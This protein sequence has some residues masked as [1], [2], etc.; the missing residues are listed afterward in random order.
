[1]KLGF[2]YHIVVYKDSE[3]RIFLP[4]YLGLFVDELAK[5]AENIY[6]FA[7][8]SK[9]VTTEQN[10]ELK[11]SNVVLVD[12]GKKQSFPITVILGYFFLRKHSDIANICDKIL[13]R[14]PSPVAPY[15][16]FA[17]KRYTKIHYLMVGDYKEGI[18]HQNFN[19]FKQLLINFFTNINELFQNK[20]I[21]GSGC[22]VN[23]AP[24][25]IKYENLNRNIEI[26]KTTTLTKDNFFNRIDTCKENSNIKL[27]FVGR[28]EKAKGMDELVATFKLLRQNK[29]PV[30]LHLAGW[31]TTDANSY[32]QQLNKSNFTSDAW[33][34][35][36]LLCGNELF[37]L[38]R[39]S[40]IFVLPSYHEGFPRV[41]WEAMANSLPVVTTKV[42]SI[43]KNLQHG[44]NAMLV[45]IK[46]ETELYIAVSDIISD[47]FLRQKLI[48]NAGVLVQ[49]CLMDV[50]VKKIIDYINE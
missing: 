48:K 20:A 21:R 49:D 15:F 35:H 6:Y 43:P 44:V 16:Y 13:V 3:G 26:V 50:Q 11:Q 1:M 24:L 25:K 38:Y 36:G 34:Y 37:Q 33:Q 18:K 2:F 8:T 29:Y 42:G 45:N 17:F 4:A 19:F 5:H 41:I 46:N 27:L 32:F 31:D 7:F 28:I 40:D 30:S 14:A 10:Y 12:L 39:E 22:I 47:K 23:S 9:K